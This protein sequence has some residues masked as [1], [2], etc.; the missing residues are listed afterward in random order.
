MSISIGRKT[1]VFIALLAVCL[2][3]ISSPPLQQEHVSGIGVLFLFFAIAA[4]FGALMMAVIGIGN[5]VTEDD[6]KGPVVINFS[7]KSAEPASPAE[8]D[9]TVNLRDYRSRR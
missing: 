1:I 3:M 6:K 5:F 9:S 4:G 7:R 2:L 8:S